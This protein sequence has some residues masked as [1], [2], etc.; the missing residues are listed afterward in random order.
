MG[1][2]QE[3]RRFEAVLRSQEVASARCDRFRLLAQG[4]DWRND[5]NECPRC[6]EIDRSCM[7]AYES[8]EVGDV[9]YRDRRLWI[10]TLQGDVEAYPMDWVVHG[11]RDYY[12][13]NP[14]LFAETFEEVGT[15]TELK[16][17]TDGDR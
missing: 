8:E 11:P 14:D 15:A 6:G 10:R 17:A 13:I 12:P 1:D 2:R 7:C 4:D 5:S 3:P 9:S 16:E